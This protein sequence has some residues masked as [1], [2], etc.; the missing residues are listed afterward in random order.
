MI[1][2]LKSLFGKSERT[3][4]PTGAWPFDQPENCA[5]IT[6]TH[7]LKEGKD[8]TRVSHDLDDHGWQFHHGGEVKTSDAMVVLLKNIVAHDPS[9]LEVADIPPGWS[10]TRTHRGAPWQ[11]AK[12]G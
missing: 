2:T 5:V 9:I 11:K 7:V 8:I 1:R 3:P 12:N 6:T 4:K 10:A